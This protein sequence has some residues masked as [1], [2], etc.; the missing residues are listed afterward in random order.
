MKSLV[1]RAFSGLFGCLVVVSTASAQRV[2]RDTAALA[3]L[4]VTATRLTTAA[5]VAAATTVLRGDDLRARG[6][7]LVQDALREVPGVAIVQNGSYGA[8]TSLFLRGGVSD[9]VKVLLDGVPLNA[10]GGSLNL[11]DL[12]TDDI[13]RIDVVRGPGSGLYGAGSGG[14]GWELGPDKR[15]SVPRFAGR[16]ARGT[17]RL[18]GSFPPLTSPAGK[19]GTFADLPRVLVTCWR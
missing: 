17:S 3:D 2:V 10:P 8:V 19:P 1:C 12:T 4:V 6:V 15:L 13:Y 18:L 16:A 5:P 14:S 9:Y 7:R 11:A